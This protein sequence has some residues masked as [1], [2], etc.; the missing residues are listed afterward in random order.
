PNMRVFELVG[1]YS[2][3]FQEF[4]AS[5]VIGD[6][7]HV[8]RINKWKNGQVGA[9]E[10]F[11]DDFTLLKQKGDEVYK[12]IPSTLDSRTIEEKYINIFDWLRLFDF[13]I[14]VI[15]IIMVIVSTINMVV[16]ILVLI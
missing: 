2:S 5:Y 12:E 16:A 9:F 13:N 11:I 1:I 4:D 14:L 6:I 15:I 3:G 7:R 8:Q 10:V